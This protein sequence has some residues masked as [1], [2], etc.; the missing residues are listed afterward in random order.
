M[1]HIV[2]ED[3]YVSIMTPLNQLLSMILLF[4]FYVLSI[5]A[6]NITAARVINDQQE[7]LLE[8][9]NISKVQKNVEDQPVEEDTD[10]DI[11]IDEA[12]RTEASKE[13][14]SSYPMKK[15]SI[16][17]QSTISGDYNTTTPMETSTGN[18]F[19]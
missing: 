5:G 6:V 7:S 14:T 15:S 19:N 16:S 1:F 8:W 4:L 2:V 18:I 9:E 10:P 11:S 12:Q 3:Q 13:S 17:K